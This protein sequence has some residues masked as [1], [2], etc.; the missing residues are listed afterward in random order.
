MQ[1]GVVMSWLATLWLLLYEQVYSYYYSL[2]HNAVYNPILEDLTSIILNK[3]PMVNHNT[4]L[5]KS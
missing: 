3:P 1:D 4:Y 5:I 2:A